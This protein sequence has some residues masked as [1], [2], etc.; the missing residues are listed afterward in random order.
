VPEV[1]FDS[2]LLGPAS[3]NLIARTQDAAKYSSRRSSTQKPPSTGGN[4]SHPATAGEALEFGRFRVLL[5]QRQLLA[6]GV[7][8]ELGARAFDI[9]IENDSALYCNLF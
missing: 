6:D 5:C 1:P 9:L 4:T 7:P 2:G 8:V 3:L